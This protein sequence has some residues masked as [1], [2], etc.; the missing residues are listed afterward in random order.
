MSDHK[1]SS[2]EDN[3][4]FDYYQ[5]TVDMYYDYMSKRKEEK[6]RYSESFNRKLREIQKENNQYIMMTFL[7][8]EL[9]ESVKNRNKTF[10]HQSENNFSGMENNIIKL[11]EDIGISV[12]FIRTKKI[13]NPSLK[14]QYEITIDINLDQCHL[15]V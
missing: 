2:S 10:V 14:K 12:R 9:V 5:K 1:D 11:A 3:D 15:R 8:P 4:H 13:K 6:Y 7:L